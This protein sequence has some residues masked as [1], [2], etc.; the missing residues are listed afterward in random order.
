VLIA[1]IL[2]IPWKSAT[3]RQKLRQTHGQEGQ[4]IKN[5]ETNFFEPKTLSFNQL[6]FYVAIEEQM[7]FISTNSFSPLNL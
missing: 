4:M 5:V 1:D 3:Y 2:Y 7:G 6:V